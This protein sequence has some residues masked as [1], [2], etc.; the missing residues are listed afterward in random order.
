MKYAVV[1]GG[2]RGIGKQITCDL[3]RKGYFVF[4]N[5]ANNEVAANKSVNDFKQ[6]SHHIKVKKADQANIEEFSAFIEMIKSQTEQLDCL[7]INTGTTL[8]KNIEDTS[9]AEWEKVMQ[10]NVNS[11]F[12][13]IRDLKPLMQKQGRI[14]FIG[15]LLGDVPHATSLIY[16]V[17]KSAIHSMAKN[18]VKFFADMKITVNIVAPGFVETDWQ[19][20]KPVEIRENILK[21]TALQRFAS[22]QD[23]SNACMFLIDN[24]YIN[25]AT[26]EV[27]G[28]YSYK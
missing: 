25:G 5:Y 10:V 26:I 22:V 2:T 7:V 18:M 17:T 28:G 1:T 8:R 6:I 9:N 12:Y 14:I 23:V 16:G 3:L 27:N 11:H 24:D 13:M 21:K 19:I 20:D 4:T 15:S